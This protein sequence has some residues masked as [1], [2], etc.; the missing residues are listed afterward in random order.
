MAGLQLC[1]CGCLPLLHVQWMSLRL[2]VCR[3]LRQCM[4][5]CL[6]LGVLQAMWLAQL[7]C[8]C[9]EKRACSGV[10]RFLKDLKLLGL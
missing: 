8:L 5:L 2:C 1:C 6:G 7:Q 9:L 3:G 10:P 4:W